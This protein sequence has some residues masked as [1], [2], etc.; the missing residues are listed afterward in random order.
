MYVCLR[1]KLE[2]ESDPEH[3]HGMNC[4]MSDQFLSW[5]WTHGG[6]RTASNRHLA[7]VGD[8]P[9]INCPIVVPPTARAL[10]ARG[11]DIVL[12]VA[13]VIFGIVVRAQ[14]PVGICCPEVQVLRAP[15]AVLVHGSAVHNGA[16]QLDILACFGAMRSI[17]SA[18]QSDQER[19]AST[20]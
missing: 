10:R 17:G 14:A 8:N 3:F 11:V 20:T 9:L 1:T 13:P 4:L 15:V 7:G 6:Q 19:V 12:A 2:S 5:T 16:F 18:G